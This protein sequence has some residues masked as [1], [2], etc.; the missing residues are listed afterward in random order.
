MDYARAAAFAG[1]VGGFSAL[2]V[3]L[4]MPS[5]DVMQDIASGKHPAALSCS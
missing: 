3:W 5:L 2:D 1:Q 4:A